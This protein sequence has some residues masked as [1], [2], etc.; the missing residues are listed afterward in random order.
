M[1]ICVESIDRGIWDAVT[2]D[3]FVSKLEKDYAFIGKNLVLLD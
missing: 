2:N 3:P 1:K